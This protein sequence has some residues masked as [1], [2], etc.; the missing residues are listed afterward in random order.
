[1]FGAMSIR[2]ATNGDL[3]EV[4]RWLKAEYEQDHDGFWSNW[5]LIQDGHNEG[6][7]YVLADPMT[8]LPIAMLLNGSCRPDI[9]SVRM[10][11]RGR[12]V[13]RRLAGFAIDLFRGRDACVI[14]IECSPRTS[15]PFWQRMGFTPYGKNRAY[16]ILSKTYPLRSDA[17]TAEVRIAFYPEARNWNADVAPLLVATPQA[18]WESDISIGFAERVVF[19]TKQYPDLGDAVVSVTVDGLELYCDKAKN[20]QDEGVGICH[21]GQAFCIDEIV[22]LQGDIVAARTAST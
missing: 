20:R 14:D 19:F 12:G 8:D 4:G 17:P 10:D 13:G 1:M 3:A 9:L 2:K 7:L 21:D 16:M 18:V 5:N 22:V 6:H 11:Y 15:I